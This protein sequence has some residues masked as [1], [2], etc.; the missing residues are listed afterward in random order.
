MVDVPPNV[1]ELRKSLADLISESQALRKDVHSAEAARRTASRINLLAVGVLAIF[2]GLLLVVTWQNNQLARRVNE[3]NT[4]MADC[5]TPGGKCYEQGRVRTDGA[6]GAV[7][8]IS[9]FVSE[10]GRLWPGESGPAY[11]RKLEQCVA[12]RLAAA[13]KTPQPAAPSPSPSK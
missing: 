5:T 1:V 7:V 11:D 6:V 4:R 13:A 8:R 10:C 12:E 2:V 9:V 3:T